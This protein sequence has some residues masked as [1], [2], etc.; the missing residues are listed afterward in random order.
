MHKVPSGQHESN[1]VRNVNHSDFLEET[2]V[3]PRV[4]YEEVSVVSS[5]S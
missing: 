3:V 5:I 2:S 4:S 1:A